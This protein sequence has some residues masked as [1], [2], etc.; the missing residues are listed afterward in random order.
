MWSILA[1]RGPHGPHCVCPMA[2]G[3]PVTIARVL[4]R[5]VHAVLTAC[6]LPAPKCC[7]HCCSSHLLWLSEMFRVC[8]S[9]EPSTSMR[10]SEQSG[11][12]LKPCLLTPV[13]HLCHSKTDHG[14]REITLCVRVQLTYLSATQKETTY[15]SC[16]TLTSTSKET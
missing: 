1:A 14:A 11:A 10:N 16:P 2:R 3:P 8:P 12:G 5:V 9:A 13:F 6:A 7:S 15:Q 4:Q